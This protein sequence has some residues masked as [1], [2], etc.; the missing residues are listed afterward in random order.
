M[1]YWLRDISENCFLVGESILWLKKFVKMTTIHF[2]TTSG[3]H[4]SMSFFLWARC[5]RLKSL[6]QP[7]A[8]TTSRHA[9][10]FTN[11]L[12]SVVFQNAGNFKTSQISRGSTSERFPIFTAFL[13]KKATKCT[14]C[15]LWK[16][17]LRMPLVELVR[18][19]RRTRKSW[20][21]FDF[22]NF[23]IRNFYVLLHG[24][25]V[26]K[27]LEKKKDAPLEMGKL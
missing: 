6:Y 4:L 12:L 2:T 23:E 14:N 3:W 24:L 26:R 17:I 25:N 5:C 1:R 15:V 11:A 20:T 8:S 21:E 13:N 10:S 22:L 7:T 27:F 16:K 18:K 9:F 19:H